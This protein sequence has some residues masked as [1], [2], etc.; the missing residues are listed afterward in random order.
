MDLRQ[1]QYVDAVARTLNFTRAATE[2]HVAQPALSHSIANLEHE[3]GLRLFDRTSRS[4]R[5]TDAGATFVARA[6][7]ILSE[8]NSLA[9]EMGEFE[10]GTV[11]TV[12]I[13]TPYHMEPELPATLVDFVA[14]NPRIEI[15]IVEL[16]GPAMLDALR[17]DEVDLGYGLVS[18]GWDS[19]EIGY[20]TG[21]IEPLMA[22][23]RGDDPLAG[24]KS[25]Q[26]AALSGRRFIA[27]Q[28]GTT[29]RNWFDR[30]F[31]DISIQPRIVIET[32]EIAAAVA[33]VNAGMGIAIVPRSVVPPIAAPAVA[34]PLADVPPAQMILAW[35][36]T[37]Y[38]TPAAERALAFA[39]AVLAPDGARASASCAS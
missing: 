34:I 23:L 29:L 15:S 35:H 1:L 10:H 20:E 26:L 39:R 17:H 19:S 4:V 31:A 36:A 2:L 11:G 28:H 21:R 22:L 25:V 7:R 18:A 5:L 14:Q 27:G 6:R 16:P 9:L 3:L 37:G 38:R 32:N 8:T 13:S 12:R 33:Y 24:R 30:V